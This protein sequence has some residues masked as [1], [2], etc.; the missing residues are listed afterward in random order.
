VYLNS[1]PISRS[2]SVSISLFSISVSS[3]LSVVNS[4]VKTARGSVGR[5]Q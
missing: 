5:C 2:A 3:V 1:R 4:A